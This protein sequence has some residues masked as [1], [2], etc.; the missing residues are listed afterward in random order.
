M[1]LRSALRA[2]LAASALLGLVPGA[3][4]QQPPADGG[5]PFTATWTLS[6]RRDVLATEGERSAA[7]VHLSGPFT[8]LS[9]EGLGTGLLGEVIG[10]DDGGTLLV[11]RALFTDE[12]G[13]RVYC[14]LTAE[15]IGQGRKASATI[16]G[17]TGRFA[18]LQGSFSFAW[19][20]VVDADG[21]EIGARAVNVEGRTRG[22][23]GAR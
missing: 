16:T 5:R 10:F 3:P 19:Q 15:P 17:G 13:D 11:G 23:K 21:G 9:G 6:G 20:Y 1:S 22:G 18:G 12:R 14:T 2:A 8:I 7:I 4:G